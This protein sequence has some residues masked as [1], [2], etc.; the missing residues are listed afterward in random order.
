MGGD[1][2]Y[3]WGGRLHFALFLLW[4]ANRAGLGT[5]DRKADLLPGRLWALWDALRLHVFLA[6][7]LFVKQVADLHDV[8]NDLHR[9]CG[10]LFTGGEVILH[11]FQVG[12]RSPALFILVPAKSFDQEKR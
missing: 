8:P 10:R 7:S 12:S 2:G 3:S 4:V 11:F 1:A 6:Q 9:P 5:G